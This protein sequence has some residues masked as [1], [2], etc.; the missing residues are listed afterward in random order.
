MIQS[1]GVKLIRPYVQ[2]SPILPF[3][4]FLRASGCG[5]HRLGNRRSVGR[6]LCR[7]CPLAHAIALGRDHRRVLGEAIEQ[8]RRQ[9]LVPAE[10]ARPLGEGEIRRDEHATSPVTSGQHVEQELAAGAVERHEA[11]LV[12]DYQVD[13]L[14]APH[15]AP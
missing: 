9:L 4:A 1:G 6:S 15:V 10:D 8:R 2:W 13:A 7:R 11:H 3:A 14:E 12:E 5:H